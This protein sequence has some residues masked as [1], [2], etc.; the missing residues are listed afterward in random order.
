GPGSPRPPVPPH[1]AVGAGEPHRPGVRRPDGDQL[2]GGCAGLALRGLLVHGVAQSP[3]TA[4]P[5]SST[6]RSS[7]TAE[8]SGSTATPTAERA[9]APASPNT[10][11]SSSLA[12]L[13]TAG[14]AVKAG[15]EAT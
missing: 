1:V 15:S 10:A 7:S 11:P 3:A 12:P 8:S 2:D 5:S 9:C 13:I 6:S 4:G 14:C